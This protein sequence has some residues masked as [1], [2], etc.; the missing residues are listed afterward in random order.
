MLVRN[1]NQ[2]EGL[3]NGTRL[4]VSHL[5]PLLIEATII[6]GTSIGKRVYLPRIKFIYK[7]SD[8]PFT[9]IR[10]QYPIKVCY[11]MTINK[12]QGQSLKKIGIYL[13]EPVFAHGQLYVALSRATSPDSIRILIESHTN[14]PQNRTKNIVF[15]DLLRRIDTTEV[16]IIVY[17][18]KLRQSYHIYLL[19]PVITLIS[20]M[21]TIYTII[22]KLSCLFFV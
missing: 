12:S 1:L 11:A 22:K 9:F 14:I 20:Y 4:M 19:L 18:S 2:R 3:C 15:K 13:P 17:F 16:E 21:K 7:S 8:L 6:T 5:L 10:K